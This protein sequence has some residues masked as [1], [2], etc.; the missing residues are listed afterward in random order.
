MSN[1]IDFL[2]DES[3]SVFVADLPGHGLSKGKFVQVKDFQ[4]YENLLVETLEVLKKK[5]MVLITL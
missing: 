4:V 2:L 5:K 1:I 3:F